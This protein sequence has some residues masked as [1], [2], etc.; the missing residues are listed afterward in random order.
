MA[1]FPGNGQHKRDAKECSG[2]GGDGIQC[3][4]GTKNL[5]IPISSNLEFPFCVQHRYLYSSIIHNSRNQI[6]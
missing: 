3:S 6:L 2:G 4:R 1:S 5:K